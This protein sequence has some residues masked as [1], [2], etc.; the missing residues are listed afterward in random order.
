MLT[1]SFFGRSLQRA[2]ALEN[3]LAARNWHGE[4]RVLDEEA[5]VSASHVA[6][7]VTLQAAIVAVTLLWVLS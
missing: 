7:I 2:R 6:L 4:L 1:A 3:G 5:A